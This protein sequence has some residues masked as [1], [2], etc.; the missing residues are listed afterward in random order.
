MRLALSA[1]IFK[2]AK[3]YTSQKRIFLISCFNMNFYY[4]RRDESLKIYLLTIAKYSII[5][6]LNYDRNL[7]L[8]FLT[9]SSPVWLYTLLFTS[10]TFISPLLKRMELKFP[11]PSFVAF[12]CF[13]SSKSPVLRLN[14]HKNLRSRISPIE[15][16]SAVI[17]T[18][19]SRFWRA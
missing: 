8:Q 11:R 1:E 10:N 19:W 14:V 6:V 2:G 7:W 3:I 5:H 18:L 13:S 16:L 4:R 15:E 17:F 12:Q 9:S